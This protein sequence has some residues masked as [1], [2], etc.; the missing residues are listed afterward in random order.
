MSL[1]LRFKFWVI[2][3]M[4][5]LIFIW[6]VSYFLVDTLNTQDWDAQV[7]RYVYTPGM[8]KKNR[9]EG[10]ATTYV[11]KHGVNAIPDIT[12]IESLKVAIWGDSYVEAWSVDD[13]NKMAQVFTQF[14]SSKGMDN[15]VG[16]GVGKSGDDAADYYF[17]IPKY[18][19]TVSSIIA[20]FIVFDSI[21]DILPDH[22]SARCTFKSTPKYNLSELKGNPQYQQI[23]KKFATYELH[24]IWNLVRTAILKL[25]LR[26]VPG[27][28]RP[29]F[30]VSQS[31]V[32]SNET[33]KNM[34]DAWSFLLEK[35]RQQTNHPIVFVYAPNI[36]K[37]KNGR[38]EFSDPDDSMINIFASECLNHDI[39]FI[40]MADDFSIYHKKTGLFPRGFSNT[41]PAEGHLN[42]EG[43]QL[44][45]KAIFNYVQN[46][47]MTANA[48]YT[49]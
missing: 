17:G 24:F 30:N 2:G 32:Q 42:A 11:G 1:L 43:H 13:K 34:L 5:S 9:S 6:I 41:K 7:N 19:S 38:I 31:K 14:C 4:V 29:S 39:G 35:F 25:K 36:P 48:F 22:D 47:K 20:H 44:V 46:M 23:K 45:A 8:I 15:L 26:F 49:N 21:S 3:F 37:L 18:E 40:N 10:W 27:P 33:K 12:Q 28:V 16:F